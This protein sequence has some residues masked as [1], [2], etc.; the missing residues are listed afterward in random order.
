MEQEVA[1]DDDVSISLP[2]GEVNKFL[3]FRLIIASIVSLEFSKD[4]PDLH[5]FNL[6]PL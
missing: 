3:M 1:W 5:K 4:M 2:H 6:T